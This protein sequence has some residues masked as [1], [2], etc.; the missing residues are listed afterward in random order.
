MLAMS[1]QKLAYTRQDQADWVRHWNAINSQQDG[2]KKAIEFRFPDVFPIRS[3]TLLRIAMIEPKTIPVLCRFPPSLNTPVSKTFP[4]LTRP[5]NLVRACWEQNI[6]VADAKTLASHLSASGFDGAELLQKASQQRLKDQLR[7]NTEQALKLGLCGV[8]T[9]RV[10]EATSQK[11]WVVKGDLVWG[12]D[13]LGVVLDLVDGWR[14][15]SSSA[16]ADVSTTHLLGDVKVGPTSKANEE[17]VE[18]AAPAKP[19]L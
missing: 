7:A 5:T 17:E 15:E 14:E 19:M 1:P 18:G 2:S 3:P 12:Q 10:L 16:V 4:Q 9:Y 6:H 11:G 8:P 13:E